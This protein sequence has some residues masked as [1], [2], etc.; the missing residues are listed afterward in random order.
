MSGAF[1]LS[2]QVLLLVLG[3]VFRLPEDGEPF[4]LGGGQWGERLV[5]RIAHDAVLGVLRALRP[6]R[7]I[8]KAEGQ[9]DRDG[10]YD[11]QVSPHAAL[12]AIGV[13]QA[14]AYEPAC[15][16]VPLPVPL[17]N[18]QVDELVSYIHGHWA[19]VREF[20]PHLQEGEN[21]VLVVVLHL[22]FLLF[23]PRPWQGSR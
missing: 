11:A 15:L 8:T 2:R 21:L 12:R 6:L 16:L 20:P 1:V 14:C 19:G 9:V 3:R 23:V 7:G 5:H 22:V 13:A 10:A 18:K 17:A 4:N